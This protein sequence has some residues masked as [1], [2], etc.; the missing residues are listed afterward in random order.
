MK[1]V[2]VSLIR[3]NCAGACVARLR[4]TAFKAI[5]IWVLC[6]IAVTPT[7]AQTTD[8]FRDCRDCPE[9]VAIPAGEFV[10]GSSQADTERAVQEAFIIFRPEVRGWL[11]SEHPQH[12]V[13]IKSPFFLGRYPI[14]RGEYAAF[15][16]KTGYSGSTICIL[17]NKR[18]RRGQGDWRSPGIPQSDRDPVVC[19]GWNDVQAYVAWLNVKLRQQNPNNTKELYRLPSEAEWEY[20]ARAGTQTARWWGDA[21]GENKANCSGC[22]SQWDGKRTAPVGSFRPNPFGLFD[23]LDNASQWVSDCW[24]ESYDGAPTNGETWATGICERHVARGGDWH[25]Q[26]WHVRAAHRVGLE[27]IPRNSLS[28]RVAKSTE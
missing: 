28:F 16:S 25:N 17:E 6:G 2:G 24:N 7:T 19:V 3:P 14:T 10:M 27:A 26:S 9:M 11:N 1:L 20:A 5:V 22:G 23:M 4:L 21:I 12:K 8:S 15:V 13:K 18:G